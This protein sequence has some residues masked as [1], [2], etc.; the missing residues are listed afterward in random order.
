MKKV[1]ICALICVL[2][3]SCVAL[4]GC[5]NTS[6]YVFSEAKIG[7]ITISVDALGNSDYVKT[8]IVLNNDGTG[9]YNVGDDSSRNFTWEKKDDIVE[10][11]YDNAEVEYFTLRDGSLIKKV[12][13]LGRTMEITYKKKQFGL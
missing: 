4:V 8:T 3:I 10:V 7:G 13:V 6:T 11:T 1:L 2:L 12:S 9:K 5:G